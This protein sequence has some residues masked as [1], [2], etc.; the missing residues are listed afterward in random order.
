V[1]SQ[2]D[3]YPGTQPTGQPEPSGSGFFVGGAQPNATFL[4]GERAIGCILQT[5]MRNSFH[6][7][8]IFLKQMFVSA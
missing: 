5:D 7:I 3:F 4:S 2:S 1:N 6:P 8:E